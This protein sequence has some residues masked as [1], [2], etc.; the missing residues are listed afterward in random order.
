MAR[1]PDDFVGPVGRLGP[2]EPGA[3]DGTVVGPGPL[4]ALEPSF[5]F[6]ETPGT[7]RQV[8]QGEPD[9]VVVGGDLSCALEFPATPLDRIR[10]VVDLPK[11]AQVSGGIGLALDLPAQEAS[12]VLVPAGHR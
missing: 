7:R 3:P 8:G 9:S 11:S 10:H 2:V 1:R 4:T 5:G 12:V 6:V